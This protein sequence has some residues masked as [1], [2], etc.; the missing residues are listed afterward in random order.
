MYAVRF[1]RSAVKDLHRLDEVVRG[2]V[3]EAVEGLARNPRPGGFRKLQGSRLEDA[4]R[5]RVG[6]L[7]CIEKRP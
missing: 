6:S 7:N 3:L 1:R 2:R 5:I 4:F